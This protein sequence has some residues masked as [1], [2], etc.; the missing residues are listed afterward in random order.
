[1]LIRLQK[2]LA[3]AN[4]ASRRKCEEIIQAGRVAVNGKTV[5]E[6]G[7]KIDDEA[8]EVTL[9]GEAVKKEQ[10]L[11][12]IMLHKP[13][14]CVT[15]ANDQFNRPTV[16][17]YVKAVDERIYP[18]GR[19]DYDTSG[20]L[21]MTN[22]GALTY[23]LTHPKHNINKTY[24]AVVDTEPTKQEI[25]SFE[26][27]LVIDGRMTAKARLTVAKVEKDRVYLKITIHEGRNRQVRKMCDAIGH[28]VRRLKRVATG[29]LTLGTLK[30][31]EYRHLT[32]DEVEY[33]RSL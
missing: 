5:T 7:T 29:R 2:Y 1:M 3:E 26:D 16:M 14:G 6:L 31:G 12:Y 20:L 28:P 30:K 17:D 25:S 32:A 4:V 24:I 18:V 21:L 33:L 15:T 11:V 10:R 23:R 19:L 27:G 8:D 9:D 22:D 13:D